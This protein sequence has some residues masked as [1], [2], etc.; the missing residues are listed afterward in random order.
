MTAERFAVSGFRCSGR[1]EPLA[2]SAGKMGRMAG[3]CTLICSLGGL[4]CSF[5]A[6]KLRVPCGLWSL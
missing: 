2:I 6:R 1:G 5:L 4:T 3:V